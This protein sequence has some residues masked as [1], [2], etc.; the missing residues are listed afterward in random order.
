MNKQCLI[1]LFAGLAFSACEKGITGAIKSTEVQEKKSNSAAAVLAP[2]VSLKADGPGGTYSLINSV[3][4][5][6]ACE[7]PDCV[8]PQDHITE[9][10]DTNLNTNVFVFSAHV[11]PDN[12]RCQS[13]DRQRTEIKTYNA[14][15]D[16][17][18]ATNG[19][20]V[21]YR[22]KFKLDAG[23]QASSS[24]THLH[25]IKA[26]DGDDSIPLITLSAR[27][28][29]N[30]SDK[31]ELIHVNSSG[32]TTKVKLANLSLFRGNWVEVIEKITFGS[33]GKYDI[34]VKKIS[35]GTELLAYSNPDMYLW[36]TGASFCRPKWGIYR[37]LN[38]SV[39]LRNEE[40]RFADFCIAEGTAICQ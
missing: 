36:R 3:L 28:G 2:G 19:E 8:H 20:T 29:A 38:N 23:F 32:T 15:P 35:D 21:T 9:I 30:N 40:V 7:V 26:V 27:Y 13:F 4:G 25:Q 18:K 5:G 11:T 17:L 31:I 39:R 24:F 10:F 37:S 16:H 22:W 1:T 14:S 6:N 33:N 12:D 34:S